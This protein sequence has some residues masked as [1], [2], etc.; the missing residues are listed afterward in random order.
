MVL[1]AAKGVEERTRK[2]FAVCRR[3]GLPVFTFV[4]KLDRDCREPIALLD[5]IELDLG[6]RLI[7]RLSRWGYRHRC[8][9][10]AR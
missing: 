2:L 9:S 8:S 3:R 6:R 5:E 10:E 1:D 4:N 7:R